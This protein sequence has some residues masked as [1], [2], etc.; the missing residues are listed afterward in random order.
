MKLHSEPVNS[1]SQSAPTQNQNSKIKNLPRLPF[2]KNFEDA[3]ALF[4]QEKDPFYLAAFLIQCW[5]G[6][7]VLRATAQYAEKKNPKERAMQSGQAWR[8]L[9]ELFESITRKGFGY[10][11]SCMFRFCASDDSPGNSLRRALVPLSIEH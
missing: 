8:S 1:D 10:L 3:A 4:E 11:L 2:M 9:L 5:L 7:L 6:G